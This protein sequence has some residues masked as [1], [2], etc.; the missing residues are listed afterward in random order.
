MAVL[1]LPTE[2]SIMTSQILQDSELFSQ[3]GSPTPL[4]KIE[5]EKLE[6]PLRF[7]SVICVNGH[8]AILSGGIDST[9]YETPS[10]NKVHTLRL[11]LDTKW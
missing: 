4:Q 1:F 10:L 5:H 9:K 7:Y 8:L 3:S 6:L 2:E 11:H